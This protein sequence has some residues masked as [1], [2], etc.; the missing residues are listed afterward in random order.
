M[1]ID[2]PFLA[3]AANNFS[4][5]PSVFMAWKM[6][7]LGFLSFYGSAHK[8]GRSDEKDARF[9]SAPNCR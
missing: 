9:I 5:W 2:H 8:Y 4:S 7:C 1:F 6:M 3:A